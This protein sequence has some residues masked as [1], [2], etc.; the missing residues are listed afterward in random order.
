[1]RHYP[2][3]NLYVVEEPTAE[4]ARFADR[5]SVPSGPL[6]GSKLFAAKGEA[7]EVEEAFHAEIPSVGDRRYAWVFPE[8]IEGTY[9]EEEAWYELR[10]FLPKGCYA[11][12]LIEELKRGPLQ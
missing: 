8:G 3:G 1:M 2:A 4:S 11:T 12:T 7:L 5:A 6:P 10:F 9:R